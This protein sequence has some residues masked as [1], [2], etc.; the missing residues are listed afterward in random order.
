MS[1]FWKDWKVHALC[2]VFVIFA[3][4]IGSQVFGPWKFGT[5]S[6]GF[7]LFPMLYVLIFGIVMA[8]MK[9][10]PRELMDIATPYISI[11][12]MWLTAK[13]ST[14]VGPNIGE[15]FKAGPALI[16]Q[17]IGNFAPMILS[18]PVA[19]FV[20]N[21]GRQ[22]VGAS[23][24]ISR[25]GSIAI[26]GNMYGLNSPEGQGVMGGYVT[27]TVLGT[28]FCGLLASFTASLGILHPYSLGMAAGTGSASMM[29]AQL[30]PLVEMFPDM[31]EQIT[32]YA[33]ASQLLTSIDGM[34]V[35]LFIA[36]PF[37]NW[38]YKKL[39]GDERHAAALAKK[40][41]ADTRLSY[42]VEEDEEVTA[43]TVTSKGELWA[44]RIKVLG[45]SAIFAL[46][47]NWINTLGG[48]PGILYVIQ[49]GGAI[50]PTATGGVRTVITF[51]DGIPAIALMAV[52]VLLGCAM[53][54]MARS[55]ANIKLP[56]IIYISLI[57][58]VMGL[59]QSP[60]MEL[61]VRETGKIALLPLC[62]PILAYAG[63]SIGKDLKAFRESG[64]SIVV[65][66][67]ISFIG[68]FIAA[69]LIAE[70]TMRFQGII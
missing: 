7:T 44:T 51:F 25:E 42:D 69:A 23:F 24:S 70:V 9:L 18:I 5:V 29:T 28:L 45:L 57:G 4:F 19:V 6:L 16:L 61:F 37:T 55:A 58:L 67:L 30:A 31:A 47:G 50:M 14:S 3:E 52:P 41:A 33:A 56:A 15:L 34:Y 20:F 40:A 62:T 48:L 65:V 27:G 59:P 22:A 60:I 1:N 11:S 46:I 39:G 26:I 13:T 63:I 12:V 36:L 66:T 64:F 21:M 35:S 68:A 49:N 32:A 54:D 10:I 43:E 2:L 8:M 53:D 38:L 17:E